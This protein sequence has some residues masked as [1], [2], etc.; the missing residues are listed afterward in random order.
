MKPFNW[1][2]PFELYSQK[3]EEE[4]ME[5]WSEFTNDKV[6]ANVQNTAN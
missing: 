6:W 1:L 2:V 3:S 4:F 5:Q